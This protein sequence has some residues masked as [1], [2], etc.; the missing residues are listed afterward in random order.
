MVTLEA[1]TQGEWRAIELSQQHQ[2]VA[3]FIEPL[4]H[5]GEYTEHELDCPTQFRTLDPPTLMTLDPPTLLVVPFRQ[6]L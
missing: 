4:H 3:R 2:P 1:P 6:F 5:P